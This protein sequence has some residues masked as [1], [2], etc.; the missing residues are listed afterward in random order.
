MDVI[1]YA[2]IGYEAYGADREWKNYAGDPM[3]TWE[4]LPTPQRQAWIAA[5]S[6]ITVKHLGE[7]YDDLAKPSATKMIDA[8]K[9]PAEADPLAGLA[10]G[11]IVHV[12]ELRGDGTWFPPLAGIVASVDVTGGRP[13]G[14]INAGVWQR[15]GSL[16]P[17]QGVPFGSGDFRYWTWPARV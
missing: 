13:T 12:F 6:A 3:P 16:V 11:R 10:P 17:A 8:M 14:R 1:D 5:T 2:R 7:V 9:L 4:E 15:D